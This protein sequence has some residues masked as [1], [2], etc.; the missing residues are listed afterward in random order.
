MLNF[1][2]EDEDFN[3]TRDIKIGVSDTT[4]NTLKQESITE[5][6][7]DIMRSLIVTTLD[8][9]KLNNRNDIKR[10]LNDLEKMVS[11]NSPDVLI[12][13]GCSRFV[14]VELNNK[15]WCKYYYI[16]QPNFIT[17]TGVN[18]QQ[19]MY[20]R[21]HIILSRYPLTRSESFGI[22]LIHI[23]DITIPFNELPMR[24]EYDDPNVQYKDMNRITVI[25]TNNS[26][27]QSENLNTNSLNNWHQLIDKIMID[28]RTV[29]I[30]GIEQNNDSIVPDNFKNA[31]V[32]LKENT[33]ANS[34]TNANVE[35]SQPLFYYSEAWE[36][37]EHTIRTNTYKFK[38]MCVDDE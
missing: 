38:L 22:P 33:S 26:T 21:T 14:Q 8:M 2:N 28:P 23:V 6:I 7:D 12:L 5:F 3:N 4:L 15:E 27:N 25:V 18:Q 20:S 19:I 24:Y 11:K 16:S 10:V 13:S 34:G 32:N 37:V 36:C 31:N 30:Q 1:S 35:D 17:N 29:L 9:S